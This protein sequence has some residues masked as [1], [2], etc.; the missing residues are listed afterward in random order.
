[1]KDFYH[2]LVGLWC[3]GKTLEVFE[4]FEISFFGDF[5]TLMHKPTYLQLLVIPTLVN[6]R[7][8]LPIRHSTHSPYMRYSSAY[9]ILV[10]TVTDFVQ[11][12]KWLLAD[13][14]QP[15]GTA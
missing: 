15:I 10:P 12:I 6:G 7:V 3:P 4:T 2:F 5:K 8:P 13:L 9:Y 11:P 14:R 1:M